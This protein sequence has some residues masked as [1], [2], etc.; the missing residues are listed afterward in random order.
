MTKLRASLAGGEVLGILAK[1]GT[2]GRTLPVTME[3]G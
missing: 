2:L 1:A 3:K